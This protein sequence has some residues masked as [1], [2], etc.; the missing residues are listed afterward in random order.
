MLYVILK[1]FLYLFIANGYCFFSLKS[2]V[3]LL[4][5]RT[6]LFY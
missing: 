5:N 6:A 4:F 3:N 2:K 1:V